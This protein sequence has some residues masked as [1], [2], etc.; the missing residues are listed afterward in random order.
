MSKHLRMRYNL[1]NAIRR[2]QYLSRITQNTRHFAAKYRALYEEL[3]Q[4]DL[5]RYIPNEMEKAKKDLDRIDET[6]EICPEEA[7]KISK[8]M[9]EYMP[10]LPHLAWEIKRSL[11]DNSSEAKDETEKETN[12]GREEYLN[13]I[14]ENTR[15]FSG[16]YSRKY[17][18]LLN[19]GLDKYL[20]EEFA[21]ADEYLENIAANLENDPE[22]ARD[23]SFE[24][25]ELM[26]R[27]PLM[28]RDAKK[29]SEA[30]EYASHHRDTGGNERRE[31]YFSRV[32]EKTREF[33]EK[34]VTK[35]DE[36][37][38]QGLEKY[39]PVEFDSIRKGLDEIGRNLD[40]D[41]ET[42]R[43]LSMQMSDTINSLPGRARAAKRATEQNRPQSVIEHHASKV[44]TGD[45]KGRNRAH[46]VENPT[47]F[48]AKRVA[49]KPSIVGNA[50]RFDTVVENEGPKLRQ[51]QDEF[52]E[53]MEHLLTA[54]KDP[55]VRDFAYDG[56]RQLQQDYAG[57]RFETIDAI[58]AERNIIRGKIKTVEANALQKAAEWKRKKAEEGAREAQ[59]QLLEIHREK[60]LQEADQNPKVLQEV[61]SGLDGLRARLQSG[62][63]I[64]AEDFQKEINELESKADEAIVDELCRKQTVKAISQTLQN[65]GFVLDKPKRIKEGGKDE[66][67]LLARKPSGNNAQFH[68]TIDGAMEFKFDGYEGAA[69]KKDLNKVIPMLKEIYGIHLSDERVLWE[70]PDR[71]SRSSL[72]TNTGNEVKHGNQQ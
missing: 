54:Y 25:K 48:E 18:D 17:D 58:N 28:A 23:L 9:G 6:L 26:Q 1:G 20:P 64:T 24:L 30:I 32:R 49:Q 8:Q 41:P 62:L 63:E 14:R 57:R 50:P 44:P 42:A 7:C 15:R 5:G 71:I 34:Y 67:L 33:Y 21:R 12:H 61:L 39:L 70:N 35:Y 47:M 11:T 40:S 22:K 4:K 37:V 2:Q 65:V 55:V 31:E 38:G 68:V 27:L 69:C 19:Q 10:S 46:E 3:D 72:P 43:D 16:E 29:E 60:I 51:A 53:F 52:D 56:I 36:L 45:E 59:K 13:R 66:V